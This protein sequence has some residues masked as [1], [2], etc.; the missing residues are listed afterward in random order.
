MSG[1]LKDL[2]FKCLACGEKLPT[3]KTTI[4]R[5]SPS[6]VGWHEVETTVYDTSKD[7]YFIRTLTPDIFLDYVDISDEKSK[8]E[9]ELRYF[10]EFIDL[11]SREYDHNFG[12]DTKCFQKILDNS[13]KVIE[14]TY[15]MGLTDDGYEIKYLKVRPIMP[16]K[17]FSEI[18]EYLSKL[19]GVSTSKKEVELEI[20]HFSEYNEI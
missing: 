17:K 13:S 8:G 7:G 18:F 12:V 4:E 1:V 20:T 11:F 3:K 19:I 16:L 10:E 6:Y 5:H 2:K 14:D 9:K 15:I